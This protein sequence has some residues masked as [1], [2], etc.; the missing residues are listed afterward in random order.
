MV[1]VAG[2][3]A[4]LVIGVCLALGGKG[5]AIIYFVLGFA[6]LAASVIWLGS[7]GA[8]FGGL[9][10]VAALLVAYGVTKAHIWKNLPSLQDSSFPHRAILAFTHGRR[11]D[12]ED[13]A[14]RRDSS[15]TSGS[16]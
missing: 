9:V 11:L 7:I 5:R 3:V 8:S 2:G 10:L 15:R 14:I 16:D 4:G 13:F 6:L 1:E 12:E